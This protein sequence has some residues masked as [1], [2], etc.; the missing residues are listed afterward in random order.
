[1]AEGHFERDRENEAGSRDE[2]LALGNLVRTP[3]L[4]QA[5]QK[6]RHIDGHEILHGNRKTAAR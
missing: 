6:S 5:G 4:S 1:V 2:A 3:G